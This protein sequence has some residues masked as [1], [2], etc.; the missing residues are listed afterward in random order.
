MAMP[1]KQN[2]ENIWHGHIALQKSEMHDQSQNDL[3][4]KGGGRRKVGSERKVFG[5]QTAV[6]LGKHLWSVTMNVLAEEKEV[7]VPA[8]FTPA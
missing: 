6:C 2:V 4:S 1:K 7:N 3:D 8:G 5:A